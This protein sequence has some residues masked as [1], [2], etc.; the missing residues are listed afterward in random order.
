MRLLIESSPVTGL[1]GAGHEGLACLSADIHHVC[2]LWSAGCRRRG[3]RLSVDGLGASSAEIVEG[4]MPALLTAAALQLD[5]AQAGEISTHI[6]WCMHIAAA[7]S[8]RILH[9]AHKQL[10]AI[11]AN[12]IIGGI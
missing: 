5:S 6:T 11:N 8:M 1:Y 2:R 7:S 3:S 12:V 10:L 4:R 9:F